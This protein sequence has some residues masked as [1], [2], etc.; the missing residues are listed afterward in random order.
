MSIRVR[1]ERFWQLSVPA[2][3]IVAYLTAAVFTF[4]AF[5]VGGFVSL[6]ASPPVAL[7]YLVVFG[8][9]FV[10]AVSRSRFL[11]RISTIEF[12]AP[13]LCGLV[14]VLASG[15]AGIW[16]AHHVNQ[17]FFHIPEKEFRP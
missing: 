16:T 3:L 14:L 7:L 10:L 2:T 15:W 9:A 1:I 6:L 13:I 17:I 4:T 12:A 11:P 5:T 8:S